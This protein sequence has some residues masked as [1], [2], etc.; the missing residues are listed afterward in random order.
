SINKGGLMRF[1]KITSNMPVMLALV[2]GIGCLTQEYMPV[3]LQQSLYAISLSI[4]E[5]LLFL[6]PLIVFSLLFGSIVNIKNSALKIIL[7]LIPLLTIS[8]L[9]ATSFALWF[10]NL[11]IAKSALVFT[12]INTNESLIPLW[13]LSL[14]KLVPNDIAMFAGIIFGVVFSYQAVK[15]GQ[16]VAEKLN[17]FAIFILK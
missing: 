15:F 3:T 16:Q 12:F 8:N 6:L 2:I 4:K 9:L 1:S 7:A 5:I 13:N 11:F 14:P 10:G 17:I